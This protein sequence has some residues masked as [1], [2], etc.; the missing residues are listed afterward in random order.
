VTGDVVRAA[1]P[2]ITPTLHPRYPLLDTMSDKADH[3]RTRRRTRRRHPPPVGTVPRPKTGRRYAHGDTGKVRRVRLELPNAAFGESQ[4][5]LD[6]LRQGARYPEARTGGVDA[7]II[8]GRGVQ[9]LLGG[10]D[11][12]VKAAQMS[13]RDAFVDVVRLHRRESRG[14]DHTCTD[15]EMPDA[16]GSNQ[17]PAPLCHPTAHGK[18]SRRPAAQTALKPAAPPSAPRCPTSLV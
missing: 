6:E 2:T 5:L 16:I 15:T 11:S 12:Q 13:F 17:T 8:T 1:N 14:G 10:F 4:I 9:A 7:S 3:G 18:R